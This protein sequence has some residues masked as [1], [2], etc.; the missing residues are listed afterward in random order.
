MFFGNLE[1]KCCQGKTVG[2]WFLSVLILKK[3]KC[4]NHASR[5]LLRSAEKLHKTTKAAF[6]GGQRQMWRKLFSGSSAA[7]GGGLGLVCSGWR[8]EGMG[9]LGRGFLKRDKIT[10]PSLKK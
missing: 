10:C 8:R 6:P 2:N 7:G 4:F 3:R 9:V 1:K 5:H